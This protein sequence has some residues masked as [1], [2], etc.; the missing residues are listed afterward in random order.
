M[1][2]HRFTSRYAEGVEQ[3]MKFAAENGVDPGWTTCPCANCG[4]LRK[5]SVDEVKR[6]LFLNGI[7]KSYKRWIWHGEEPSSTVT[8]EI[9]ERHFS[10]SSEPAPAN[11]EY[12]DHFSEMF[13]AAA[14]EEDYVD[15]PDAFVD[16]A[17][18]AECPLYEGS[19]ISK[20]SFLI[21]LYNLKARNGW[22]DTGFDQLLK[23][24]NEVFPEGNRV[25]PSMYEA[26]KTL[27]V[28]SIGYEKIH[29][30]SNDCILFRGEYAN[31]ETCP[32]CNLPRWKLKKNSKDVMVGTP[33]KVLWY[34]PPIPRF[35]RMF[36][37]P[38]HAKNYVKIN[39]CKQWCTFI[40]VLNTPMFV[41]EFV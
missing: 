29:A 38:E 9:R 34:I 41:L 40:F 26:K 3:F 32:T 10:S 14:P 36:Q 30:C 7:D 16:Q 20:M 6:H 33:S 39:I 17:K 5:L 11:D 2:V 25:P 22:S 8:S 28:M 23:L 19:K 13:D 27:R 4:N 37:H 24:L 21:R 35:K 31:A 1:F 15:Q 12:D 18:D